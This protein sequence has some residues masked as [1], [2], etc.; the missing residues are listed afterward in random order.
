MRVA[1]SEGQGARKQERL[2]ANLWVL[3]ARV[4]WP[5]GWSSVRRYGRWR[6]SSSVAVLRSKSGR[7]ERPRSFRE[8]RGFGSVV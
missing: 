5:I 2:E 4:G 7:F 3:V 6:V 8:P 1:G